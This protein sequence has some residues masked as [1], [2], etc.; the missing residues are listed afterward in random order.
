MF[1]EL[2]GVT[3]RE[4]P[5]AL[6]VLTKRVVADVLNLDDYRG[7]R[8]RKGNVGDQGGPGEQGPEGIPGRPGMDGIDGATGA[9][10]D[11]GPDGDRGKRGYKG[12]Q[13]R[14]GEL[15]VQGPKGEK[16]D[17]GPTPAH[18]WNG[19]RLAFQ[20]PGGKFGKS[21]EL[22]GPGGGRGGAGTT[23]QFKSIGLNGTDLEF[24]KLGAM[25]SDFSVDL[26]SLGGGGEVSQAQRV[27]EVGDVMYIG[28]A[29]PGTLESAALWAIKRVTF[30]TAGSDT[31]IDTE[32][33][34]GAA[35][36]DRVWDNRLAESYS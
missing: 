12:E 11:Q 2:E 7:R 3:F 26:S 22:R 35:V 18:N 34:N 28:T 20:E 33:A 4:V 14:A 8:G 30:L 17:V 19:T 9:T 6:V 16:G 5:E 1:K 36:A 25:G 32:W 29:A 23:E 27:D 21:V 24:R 10:G 15:G 13:G 31:D